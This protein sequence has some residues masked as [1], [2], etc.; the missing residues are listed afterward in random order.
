MAVAIRASVAGDELNL[1]SRQL[2]TDIPNGTC[3]NFV[4]YLSIL[5]SQD[6]D[7]VASFSFDEDLELLAF[8]LDGLHE[9]LNRVKQKPYFETKDTDSRPDEEVANEF[10]SYHKA[11]SIVLDVRSID[12]L[13]RSW[14]YEGFLI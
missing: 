2:F 6:E 12:R 1:Q 3:A 5:S 8:L 4:P 9:D 7:L 10:W 14:I 13:Q 11:N